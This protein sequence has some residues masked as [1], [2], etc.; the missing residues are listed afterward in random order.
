MR[1][2]ELIDFS[3]TEKAISQLYSDGMAR[4][5]YP[6]LVLF[7]PTSTPHFSEE[8]RPENWHHKW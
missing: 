8:S 4:P 2:N 7:N 1:I 5:S 6:P 3:P